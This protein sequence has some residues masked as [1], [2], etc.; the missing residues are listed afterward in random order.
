[1]KKALCVLLAF[2][3]LFTLLPGC[4]ILKKPSP[5]SEVKITLPSS[6]GMQKTVEGE[7]VLTTQM[8][9]LTR[10]YID[11]I[12][13][14]DTDSFDA[15]K[16]NTLLARAQETARVAEAL[17][18]SM[19]NHVEI[20]EKVE[21]SGSLKPRKRAT[22]AP[23][24]VS[25]AGGFALLPVA[26]AEE[27]S[28]AVRYAEEL[29]QTFDTAKSGQKLKILAE[30]YGTDIKKAKVMLEQA[31]AILEGA[32]YAD[33]ADF[34]NKC[35]EAAVET[36][37]AAS[38]I[39]FGV[40]LAPVVAAG[41]LAVGGATAAGIIEAGGLV[42]SGVNAVIDMGTA[43]TIHIT[44]GE[45]N[46][47]TAAFEKTSEMMAPVTAFFAIGGGIQNFKDFRNPEKAAAAVD[48]AAQAFLPGIGLAR[49]YVQDGTILGVSAN[50]VEGVR[51]IL[52]R[53]APASDPD[54]AKE[55]VEKTGI[56]EDT[57]K[58]SYPEGYIKAMEVIAEPRN[59]VDIEKVMESIDEAFRK[60]AS[61]EGIRLEATPAPTEEPSEEPTQTPAP[62]ETPPPPN[63]NGLPAEMV[64]GVY[65]FVELEY[66]GYIRFDVVDAT[67]LQVTD[68]GDGES[69]PGDYDPASGILYAV[70]SEQFNWT[71]TVKF[72]DTG[73]GVK[74]EL[75]ETLG[76]MSVEATAMKE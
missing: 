32:A 53:S 1:M 24:T 71:L 46:D 54:A 7:T 22:L 76:G 23:L 63:N 19:E 34:E 70:L 52:V 37:A 72:T 49:D 11:K 56:A 29:T 20:L 74:A 42:T 64:A 58:A 30:K 6:S 75:S 39:G 5:V 21:Q 35:Y 25:P 69:F 40:A 28:A 67:H 59:P 51:E 65:D 50:I 13:N 36:K 68:L 2:A 47:Y 57:P 33:Q 12:E 8:Y 9:L 3:L 26:H 27:K 15:Q 48:N 4:G 16:F 43:V 60:A 45:G 66:S 44:N 73:N 55:V 14:F 41:S 31:Q 10:A 18:A 17:S 38:V 62:S 61:E